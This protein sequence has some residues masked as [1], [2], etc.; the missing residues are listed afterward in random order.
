MRCKSCDY[1][2]WQI[3]DRQC[4]ECGAAFKP[5]EFEF[6]VN[7][8][9]FCCPHCAQEY[10]G[11]GEHGHLVPGSFVCVK[12][13]NPVTMDEMVLLPADGVSEKQTEVGS[14]PWLERGK[15]RGFWSALLGTTGKA[16]IT[17]GR[18]MQHTP[19]ESSA[20]SALLYA[21][22]AQFL[23]TL[24]TVL[25]LLLFFVFTGA[26][27]MPGPG[28]GQGGGPG[29][30]G[31]VI[32]A[33]IAMM[34]GFGVFFLVGWIVSLLVVAL[35]AHGLLRLTG[36]CAHGVGRTFQAVA[37]SSG[38]N[39]ISAVPCIGYYFGWI[40]WLVSA[41][42][43]VKDAQRVSG[44]RACAAVLTVPLLLIAGTIALYAVLIVSVIGAA[45]GMANIQGGTA[46][47]MMQSRVQ[48]MTTALTTQAPPRHAAELLRTGDIS[49]IDLFDMSSSAASGYITRAAAVPLGST[50]LA[51]FDLATPE[52]QR[53]HVAEA[54]AGLPPSAVAYRLGDTVFTHCGIDPMVIPAGDPAGKLWMVV[55]H[56]GPTGVRPPSV[57]VV[58][59][60]DGTTSNITITN[61]DQEMAKQNALR[62]SV[63]LSPLPVLESILE[64]A[65]A[66]G[67]A[68]P[69]FAIPPG[70]TPPPK[71]PAADP[72]VGPAADPG[73]DPAGD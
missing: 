58:G 25:P 54:V 47:I 34:A 6:N 21:L 2:L 20:G 71:D 63:G 5:S 32:G 23:T 39:V 42:V 51:Q 45:G 36:G 12:C 17:P 48:S 28:A 33:S 46:T 52:K 40:W 29:A 57:I 73:V 26:M 19:V 56:P 69:A 7:S 3:K 53:G 37:Y 68:A 55:A 41:C 44:M 38:A 4:P 24:L 11:T 65:A 22:I 66:V 1:P 15:R 27:A 60:A 62:A 8:V 64:S 9:R 18:L 50:T 10:Y 30:A 14:N 35:I 59:H 72:A 49:M 13:S 16:L 61:F 31:A 67:P 70:G 43:A